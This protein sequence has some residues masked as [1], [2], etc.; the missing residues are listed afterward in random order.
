MWGQCSG[1]RAQLSPGMEASGWPLGRI[2]I[3]GDHPQATAE[4]KNHN[5]PTSGPHARPEQTEAPSATLT[6][7]TSQPPETLGPHT[8]RG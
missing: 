8:R 5:P 4:P 1:S 7:S 6:Q 3:V 2:S